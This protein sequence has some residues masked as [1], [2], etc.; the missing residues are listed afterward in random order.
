VSTLEPVGSDDILYR[1]RAEVIVRK[2]A[3]KRA[4]ATAYSVSIRD[5]EWVHG[6]VSD[7]AFE[8]ERLRK[9]CSQMQS[10][11]LIS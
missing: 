2:V 9:I 6:L 11:G 4:R 10:S 3:L 5:D 7:A 1:L 8:I